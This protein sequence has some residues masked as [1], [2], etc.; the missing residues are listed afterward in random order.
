MRIG[1]DSDVQHNGKLL[2]EDRAV[3]FINFSL[4]VPSKTKVI[5]FVELFKPEKM[6]HSHVTYIKVRSVFLKVNHPKI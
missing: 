2:F 3:L 1:G 4:P 6:G 5:E